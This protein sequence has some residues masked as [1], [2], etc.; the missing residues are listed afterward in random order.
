[1]VEPEIN[2]LAVLGAAVVYMMVGALWYGPLF[3]KPWLKAMQL[4]EEALEELK[5][6]AKNGYLLT[7]IAGLVMAMVL[8]HWVDYVSATT[9][10]AGAET[11]FW[12]WLG[13]V[14]TS[15]VGQTVFEGRPWKL[16][17][18]ST[19]YHLVTLTIMG[20]VLAVWA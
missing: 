10:S 9:F 16:Y 12:A 15:A 5:K 2:W 3:S 14:V 4:S 11:G 1:M 7:T 19:G 8:A 13:F 18:L 6:Q 20:G 17:A